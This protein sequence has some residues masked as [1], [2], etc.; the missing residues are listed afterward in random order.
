MEPARTLP[1]SSGTDVFSLYKYAFMFYVL[2]RREE[3]TS[4][5]IQEGGRDVATF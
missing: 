5:F 1:Q 2:Y 4:C 3:E